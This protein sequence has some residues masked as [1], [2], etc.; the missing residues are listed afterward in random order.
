L[1]AYVW[2]LSHKTASGSKASPE[3][4]LIPGEKVFPESLT[5]ASDGIEGKAF[6]GAGRKKQSPL[7]YTTK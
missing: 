7:D 1:A 6:D 3:E 2:A 5:Y 4:L